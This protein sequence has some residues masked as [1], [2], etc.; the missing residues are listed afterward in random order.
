MPAPPSF[1]RYEPSIEQKQPRED[2]LIKN[3][4]ES[5][6]RVNRRVFDRHRHAQRD[7]HAKCHGVL[8][9]ELVVYDGLDEPLRQGLF[10]RPATYPVIVR[11][12]SAPG[13]LQPDS[14]PAPRGMAIKII[15]AAGPKAL[16]SHEAEVTQDLLLVN[17]PVIAFGHVE[18][19]WRL[20]QTLEKHGAQPPALKAS[21][22]R[23]ARVANGALKLAGRGNEYLEALGPPQTHPLGETFH[24]MAALRHG[25]YVAKLRA[26]PLSASVRELT[27]RAIDA[28]AGDSPLRDLVVDFFAK[29]GAE[30]ELR[31]QLCTDLGTMPV[32]DASIEWSDA[33]SPPRGV[34]KLVLPPQDAFSPARRVYADDVLSFNPWHCLVEHRPLGS[35]MR[36]RAEA[37]ERSSRFR[38]E[39]NARPRVEPRDI[40]ELPD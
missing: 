26:A 32:E 8:R 38:H 5:M 18:A 17:R 9:G 22:A 20:Q 11:L 24:S 10:R 37:Y 19:Y 4:V 13:D 15:G 30:Y 12:S 27:G 7:A 35:I 23:L 3:I 36:V 40:S 2:E 29:E 33:A 34:A 31:A 16:P 28:S 25:D 14:V 6:A 39:M 1:V 21:V